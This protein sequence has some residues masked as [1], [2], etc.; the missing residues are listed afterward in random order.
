MARGF[1]AITKVTIHASKRDVWNAL[2]NP[3]KVKQYMHGTEM[4]TDWKEGSPIFWRGE[5]KGRPYEDKGTVLA[6]EPQKLLKY[7]HWSPM[8]GSEDKPENYHTVTCELAGKDG[9]TTLTLR[10]DNN[11][12]QE[13]ADKMADQ[14]WGPVMDGL[15]A[16]AEKPAK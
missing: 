5:W 9:E 10:Q 16:V 8:G 15:K 4:S 1:E 3:E 11:A 12:T 13:E 6:V 7:T 2:T 14:N